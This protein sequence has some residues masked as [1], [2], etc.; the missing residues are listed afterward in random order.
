MTCFEK[1]S[2]LRAARIAEKTF[3]LS[4]KVREGAEKFIGPPSIELS[5]VSLVYDGNSQPVLKDLFLCVPGGS[6]LGILGPSGSGKTTV[7]KVILGI[8]EPTSG[9]VTVGNVSAREAFAK[10]MVSVGYVGPDPL[11]IEGTVEENLK[12]GLVGVVTD[13]D[14][15]DALGKTQMRERI[16]DF[17]DGLRQN[18]NEHADILSAGQKQRL[19]LARA[20]VSRPDILILDEP[21][22]NLDESTELEI[23]KVIAGLKGVCTTVIVSHRK[24]ILSSV[25]SI[26]DLSN[27]FLTRGNV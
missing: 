16:E 15:W 5:D 23:S 7:L 3:V 6:Q 4:Q 18:L 21:S 22:A 2:E 25:D 1:G 27:S 10:G 11:L 24:G 20:L 9:R 17:R 13:A 8:L 26:L 12:Y 14:L 19:S